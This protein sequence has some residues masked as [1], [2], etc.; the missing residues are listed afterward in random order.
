MMKMALLLCRGLLFGQTE[1]G[2]GAIWV[3]SEKSA[4][5][6]LFLYRY[7]RFLCAVGLY[8]KNSILD[9]QIMKNEYLASRFFPIDPK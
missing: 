6:I 8:R 3:Y 5:Q 4:F 1:Y 9:T 2:G 7:H